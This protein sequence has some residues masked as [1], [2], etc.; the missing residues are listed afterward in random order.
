MWVL[1]DLL[2]QEENDSMENLFSKSKHITSR[3]KPSNTQIEAFYLLNP[4][5]C[6]EGFY[7]WR[8]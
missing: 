7:Q 2:F 5:Q 1:V 4:A 8:G 6:Q 3:L